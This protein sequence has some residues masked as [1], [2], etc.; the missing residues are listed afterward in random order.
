M[1][2]LQIYQNFIYQ[3][4]HNFH[5]NILDNFLHELY[6]SKILRKIICME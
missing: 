2:G 5:F 3:E 6:N 1:L 4:Q